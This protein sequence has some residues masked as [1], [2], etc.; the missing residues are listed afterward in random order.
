M[1]GSWHEQRNR[2]TTYNAQRVSNQSVEENGTGILD[3][4]DLDYPEDIIGIYLQRWHLT[5]PEVIPQNTTA[6]LPS[7]GGCEHYRDMLINLSSSTRSLIP[8]YREPCL[9]RWRT[10]NHG[11]HSFL[12]TTARRYTQGGLL[13]V[14]LT[15]PD[16]AVAVNEL[17]KHLPCTNNSGKTMW[18][19]VKIPEGNKTPQYTAVLTSSKHRS[20]HAAYRYPWTRDERRSIEMWASNLLPHR[21]TDSLLV[22]NPAKK[23][24]ITY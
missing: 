13:Y 10:A 15:R 5:E 23:K 12:Q 11:R 9:N 22:N 18:T 3:T 6:A 2:N 21:I 20:I 16:C 1:S 14:L 19:S 24:T 17:T 8:R 7:C 4:K